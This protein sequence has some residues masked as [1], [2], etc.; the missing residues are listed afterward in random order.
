[1][2]APVDKAGRHLACPSCGEPIE[3][4]RKAGRPRKICRSNT[5]QRAWTNSHLRGNGRPLGLY[6]IACREPLAVPHKR[7]CPMRGAA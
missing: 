6:C 7:D 1:M 3:V 4:R 2:T 5:C